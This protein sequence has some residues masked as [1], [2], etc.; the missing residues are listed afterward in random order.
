MLEKIMNYSDAAEF[1][2]SNKSSKGLDKFAKAIIKK[3]INEGVF[4]FDNEDVNQAVNS[5]RLMNAG[6]VVLNVGANEAFDYKEVAKVFFSEA[7][8]VMEP[9]NV[10]ELVDLTQAVYSTGSGDTLND[11]LWGAKLIE[12][13]TQ[14]PSA[15]SSALL[16]I[17]ELY[18]NEDEEDKGR[19]VANSLIGKASTMYMAVSAANE[20]ID[21]LEDY[22]LAKKIMKRAI[23]DKLDTDEG[24]LDMLHEDVKKVL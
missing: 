11:K 7:E 21:W 23:D 20:V 18:L 16:S 10:E 2:I 17:M 6:G 13:V 5:Y 22:E 15:D 12:K 8:N 1:I 3:G 19:E 24:D 14:H 9:D 4:Y